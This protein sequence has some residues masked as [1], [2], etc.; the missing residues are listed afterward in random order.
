MRKSQCFPPLDLT[1]SIAS[2][3]AVLDFLRHLPEASGGARIGHERY[4]S[5]RPG[6]VSN[7]GVEGRSVPGSAPIAELAQTECVMTSRGG[8]TGCSQASILVTFTIQ[9]YGLVAI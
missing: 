6:L 2:K 1:M 3:A 9:R 7:Q 4:V 5:A 8:G